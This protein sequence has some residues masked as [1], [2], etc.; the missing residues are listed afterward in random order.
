MHE[1]LFSLWCKSRCGLLWRH[2]IKKGV[3][4]P[5]DQKMLIS[6][7][8]AIKQKK[9]QIIHSK[10]V[11]RK[12]SSFDSL[13]PLILS[14]SIFSFKFERASEEKKS[15]FP[16]I[17]ALFFCTL[18]LVYSVWFLFISFFLSCRWEN[19]KNTCH[20]CWGLEH[21]FGAHPSGRLH[22][23]VNSFSLQ[24]TLLRGTDSNGYTRDK[25]WGYACDLVRSS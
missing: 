2:G 8:V 12:L 3:E 21:W 20:C 7:S 1:G 5:S 17:V 13:I 22:L 6:F 4:L 16:I 19:H 14:W 11:L 15:R 9:R 18:C 10:T 24:H 23:S 25:M